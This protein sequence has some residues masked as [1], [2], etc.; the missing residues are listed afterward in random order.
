MSLLRNAA[1]D[2]AVLV[3]QRERLGC[4]VLINHCDLVCATDITKPYQGLAMMDHHIVAGVLNAETNVT[5]KLSAIHTISASIIEPA[6]ACTTCTILREAYSKDSQ[7]NATIG[8][9]WQGVDRPLESLVLRENSEVRGLTTAY[10]KHRTKYLCRVTY[11][12]I[13]P[14]WTPR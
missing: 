14:R 2:T 9:T 13:C 11:R 5:P 12:S 4:T 6:V 1:L 8:I 3:G 10:T 7:E